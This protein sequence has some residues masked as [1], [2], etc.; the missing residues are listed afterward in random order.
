LAATVGAKV[1]IIAFDPSTRVQ[2]FA[3]ETPQPI[4]TRNLGTL[5]TLGIHG[6]A[7][8][9]RRLQFFNER[10]TQERDDQGKCP[11]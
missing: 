2:A 10:S 8:S 1:T 6:Y 11:G 7:N 9:Y 3:F 5:I 4:L